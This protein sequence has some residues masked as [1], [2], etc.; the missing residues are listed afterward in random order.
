MVP[1][2]LWLASERSDGVT[3]QRFVASR[4]G[5]EVTE[6]AAIK[7]ARENAGWPGT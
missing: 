2:L 3:G 1:P 7:A 6:D 5:S 4:W